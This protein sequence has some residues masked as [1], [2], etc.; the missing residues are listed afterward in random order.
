MSPGPFA[1]THDDALQ[2]MSGNERFFVVIRPSQHGEEPK[3]WAD[4]FETAEEAQQWIDELDASDAAYLPFV[5]A[6]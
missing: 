1:A 6:A 3:V 2:G 5:E 4:G